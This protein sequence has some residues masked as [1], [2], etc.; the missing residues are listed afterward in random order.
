MAQ[1]E[2]DHADIRYIER[3]LLRLCNDESFEEESDILL[4]IVPLGSWIIKF[5]KQ[6]TIINNWYDKIISYIFHDIIENFYHCCPNNFLFLLF[7]SEN[8]F[9]RADITCTVSFLNFSFFVSM[10][11]GGE[12]ISDGLA[13]KK[14]R[15]TGSE[16]VANTFFRKFKIAI[17][18]ALSRNGPDSPDPNS[19]TQP[20]RTGVLLKKRDLF[21][22]WRSRHFRVFYG[23]LDYFIAEEDTQPRGSVDLMGAKVFLSGQAWIGG[24]E[25]WTVRYIESSEIMKEF[26]KC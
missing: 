18:A 3:I 2:G 9:T 23:R 14:I 15:V 26:Y 4:E 16:N 12:G 20:L 5:R 22:G 25:H 1:S 10:V 11:N 7:D 19:L 17:E 21:S 24:V 6:G 13:Q 8:I